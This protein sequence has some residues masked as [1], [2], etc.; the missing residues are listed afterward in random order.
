[1]ATT[2]VRCIYK[3]STSQYIKDGGKLESLSIQGINGL[4]GWSNCEPSYDDIKVWGGHVCNYYNIVF[5]SLQENCSARD[6]G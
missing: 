3:T 6:I 4:P 2:C 1:M 5:S